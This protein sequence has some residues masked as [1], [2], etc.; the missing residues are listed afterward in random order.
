MELQ[1]ANPFLAVHCELARG[2][3]DGPGSAQTRR[4]TSFT[5]KTAVQ[6]VSVTGTGFDAING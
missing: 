5:R 3:Q 4:G 1:A 6:G 2:P